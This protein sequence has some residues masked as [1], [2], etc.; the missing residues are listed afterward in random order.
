LLSVPPHYR[1]RRL[2]A[3]AD[4]AAFVDI[5]ALGGNAP[6]DILSGQYRCHLPATLTRRFASH[7]IMGVKRFSTASLQF[8][9]RDTRDRYLAS[10]QFDGEALRRQS[11][12]GSNKQIS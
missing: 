11:A 3:N 7:A 10:R 12:R 1:G 2:E 5:S 9:A 4:A 6:D 8:S